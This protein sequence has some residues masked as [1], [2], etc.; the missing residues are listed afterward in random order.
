MLSL[1]SNSTI[2]NIAQNTSSRVA[3]ETALKAVGRPSFILIDN[4]IS[5]DTKKYAA[6]KEF[7]YQATCLAVYLAII[8]PIFK[9]GSFALGKKLFKD[10]PEFQK[11]IDANEYLDYY[12]YAE[13]GLQNRLASL[14]KDH[15]ENKFMHDGLRDALKN[16]EHPEKYPLIKGTIEFGS[17][18]GSILG[19]ALLAPEVSHRTIHPMMRML[20]LEKKPEKTETNEKLDV[21]A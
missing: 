14:K 21:K 1:I 6:A 20:G 18:I 17:L 4:D 8:P 19:L 3:A 12:K 7:L 11:F 13:K 9:K 16:I 2:A 15:S 10:A 5:A